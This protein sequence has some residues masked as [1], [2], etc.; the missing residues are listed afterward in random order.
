MEKKNDASRLLNDGAE[1]E[2]VLCLYVFRR[3]ESSHVG[4]KNLYYR[5]HT[6]SN[7]PL[8]LWSLDTH[9]EIY[10]HPSPS[11]LQMP[12]VDQKLVVALRRLGQRGQKMGEEDL[13]VVRE[14]V[15]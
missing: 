14:E 5:A 11:P 4:R 1:S 13:K 8:R 10:I 7:F 6:L 3:S 15:H 12:T 2:S 9:P